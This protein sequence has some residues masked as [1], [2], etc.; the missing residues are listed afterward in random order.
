M[1]FTKNTMTVTQID[2]NFTGFNSNFT[3]IKRILLG[4]NWML[5]GLNRILLRLNWML[6]R[7]ES[8]ENRRSGPATVK[9]QTFACIILSDHVWIILSEIDHLVIRSLDILLKLQDKSHGLAVSVARQKPGHTLQTILSAYDVPCASH[10]PSRWESPVEK[11][12]RT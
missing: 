7:F 10:R 5:L 6:L 4:L 3:E 12:C 1:N 2:L 9:I 11:R 8:D